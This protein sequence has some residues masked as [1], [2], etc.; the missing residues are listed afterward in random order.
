MILG[1]IVAWFFGVNAERTA[2]EDMARPL[3]LVRPGA[4]AVSAQFR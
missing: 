2:P 1:G 4:S 3:S